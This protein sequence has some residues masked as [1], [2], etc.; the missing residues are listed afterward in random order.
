MYYVIDNNYFVCRW[1]TTTWNL[2]ACS[3][4]VVNIPAQE[5]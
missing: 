4:V 3:V 1:E 5:H 2:L